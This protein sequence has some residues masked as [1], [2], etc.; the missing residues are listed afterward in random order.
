MLSC[1]GIPAGTVG[2]A[3][4]GIPGLVLH[5]DLLEL[6]VADP[7]LDVIT[8]DIGGSIPEDRDQQE[9]KY[10]AFHRLL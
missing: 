2:I 10:Y 8:S 5:K 6:L 4:I 9:G 1:H 7:V 3:R